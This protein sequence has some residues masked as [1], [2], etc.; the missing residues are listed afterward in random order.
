MVEHQPKQDFSHFHFCS[1]PNFG[2]AFAVRE[3][4]TLN[5]EMMKELKRKY[6][7]QKGQAIYLLKNGNINAYLAKLIEVNDVKLQM[8][9]VAANY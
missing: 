5:P 8:I 1:L 2:T 6:I 7:A 4:T 9:Q 3:I